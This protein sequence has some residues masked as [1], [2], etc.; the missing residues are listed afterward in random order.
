MTIINKNKIQQVKINKEDASKA[1]I[2]VIDSNFNTL[3]INVKGEH[4]ETLKVKSFEELEGKYIKCVGFKNGSFL[5]IDAEKSF[6]LLENGEEYAAIIDAIDNVIIV[7]V[8]QNK[9]KESILIVKTEKNAIMKIKNKNIS[10]SF[11]TL[12]S[13]TGKRVNLFDVSIF[14]TKEG[15]VFYSLKEQ[16]TIKTIAPETK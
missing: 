15:Q 11:K 3:W 5:N 16:G 1:A 13:L 9:N 12:E 8:E 6:S 7:K 14:K 10:I 4:L 2:S